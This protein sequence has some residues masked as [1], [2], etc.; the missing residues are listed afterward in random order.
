M[1]V[2]ESTIRLLQE[3]PLDGPANMARDEA[4]MQSVGLG[5]SPPTLRL[6]IF[7]FQS[8][9]NLYHLGGVATLS[10]IK[11]YQSYCIRCAAHDFLI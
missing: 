2:S 5:E 10:Y 8:S 4:L 7:L 9:Q 1:I 11:V 6:E 3:P